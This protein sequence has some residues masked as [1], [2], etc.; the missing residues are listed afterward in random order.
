MLMLGLVS[1]S[2]QTT[3][4]KVCTKA[5]VSSVSKAD[6]NPADCKKICPDFDPD[7]CP[8]ICKPFC[9]A[10]GKL[11]KQT[12]PQPTIHKVAAVA[13]PKLVAKKE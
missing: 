12:Q 7:K 4:K 11:A 8:P 13:D 2:A 5:K 10:K 9:D 6:C 3:A 1:V